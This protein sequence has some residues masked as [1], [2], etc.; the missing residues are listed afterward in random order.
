MQSVPCM[1]YTYIALLKY[2]EAIFIGCCVGTHRYT[3]IHLSRVFVCVHTESPN[4]MLNSLYLSILF[5]EDLASLVLI[6]YT[7]AFLL[8]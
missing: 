2:S 5:V 3:Y 4:R 6:L 8:T 7:R 1:L